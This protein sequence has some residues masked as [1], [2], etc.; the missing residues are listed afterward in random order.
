MT[1]RFSGTH[2]DDENLE[3]PISSTQSTVVSVLRSLLFLPST[4]LDRFK[5]AID[6]GA[7]AVV[8]DLEDGV[9]AGARA[10]ARKALG[11]LAE[12]QFDGVE[13]PVY[14]R[15]NAQRCRDGVLDLAS[16]L[17]WQTWPSGFMLPKVE[18][19]GEVHQFAQL[20]ETEGRRI[21]LLPV[22]E[23][24]I[25]LARVDGIAAE[26]RGISGLAFGSADYTSETTGTMDRCSLLGPRGRIV[27]AAAIAR[28]PA[29][30]GVTLDLD[31]SDGLEAECRHI[32]ALGFAGKIAIHPKQVPVI[33]RVFLPTSEELDWAA[34]VIEASK[35]TDAGAFSFRGQMIDAPVLARARRLLGQP[36]QDP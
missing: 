35:G 8:L 24:A 10:E 12:R 31:D 28:A 11:E 15:L 20:A 26:A 27:N 5:K 36:K 19:A 4:R 34:G 1:V 18:T 2:F 21:D 17:A 32:R 6:S 7:D 14:V 3:K 22:I 13:T 25:G 30:D 29:I 9:E 23:T 16:I 33:N